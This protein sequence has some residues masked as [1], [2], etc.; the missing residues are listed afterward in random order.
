[1]GVF[2]APAALATVAAVLASTACAET[3]RWCPTKSMLVE[4]AT[5]DAIGIADDQCSHWY[6]SAR[7]H[8]LVT[9]FSFNTQSVLKVRGRWDGPLR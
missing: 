3:F 1:M 2:R 9:D 4:N 6:V 8:V 7:D 5:A